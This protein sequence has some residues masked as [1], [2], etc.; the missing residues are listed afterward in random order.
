MVKIK[1]KVVNTAVNENFNTMVNGVANQ[2]INNS[3]TITLRSL[4]QATA[5]TGSQLTLIVSD[6]G[7]IKPGQEGEITFTAVASETE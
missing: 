5:N 3:Y 1:A 2:G 6:L 4:E 7:D